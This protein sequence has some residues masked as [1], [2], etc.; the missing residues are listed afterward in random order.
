[1]KVNSVLVV[2]MN[3]ITFFNS[4]ARITRKRQLRSQGILK[5]T[6]PRLETRPNIRCV[7]RTANAIVHLRIADYRDS[8]QFSFDIWMYQKKSAR[9]RNQNKRSSNRITR[10]VS[11]E[12]LKN[13][14]WLRIA[15]PLVPSLAFPFCAFLR[16]KEKTPQ[17]A[18][19][20]F[21]SRHLKINTVEEIATKNVARAR[22][23]CNNDNKKTTKM[24]KA[25]CKTMCD[26]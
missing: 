2:D 24:L 9:T 16:E 5:N 18:K 10:S 13:R 14:E 3:G 8:G 1:M 6:S 4:A 25:N 22:V 17:F 21:I 23:A 11:S 19:R 12:R 7:T 26:K 20:A 15:A